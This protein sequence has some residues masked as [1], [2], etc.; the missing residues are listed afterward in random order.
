MSCCA[1]ST[2][3][4]VSTTTG[5]LRLSPTGS[6]FGE[7]SSSLSTPPLS[8]PSTQEAARGATSGAR[9]ARPSASLAQT[10]SAPTPSSCVLRVAASLCS[11]SRSQLERRGCPVRPSSVPL[12]SP[13]RAAPPA[14][15]QHCS[16]AAAVV[17]TTRLV[18]ARSFA[19]S[20]LSLPLHGTANV[21][22]SLPDLSDVL[23]ELRLDSPPHASRLPAR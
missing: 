23:A 2:S 13:V 17:R 19:A 22:G 11:P 16:V 12:P 6:R 5:E 21:D 18:V 7:E 10:R 14:G 1:I 9:S 20:L 3:S 8:R 15:Q 4:P